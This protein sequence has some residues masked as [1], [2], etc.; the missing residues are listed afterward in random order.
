VGIFN[1]EDSRPE[2]EPASVNVERRFSPLVQLNLT[3]DNGLRTQVGYET[4]RITSLSLSNTRVIERTSKGLRLSMAYTL[5]NFRI[6]FVRRTA[7][8]VDLT[9]NGSFV[10]DSEIRFL[11]DADLDRV[12]Q[13][14]SSV[15][16][17]DP[18]LYSFTPAPPTGQSRI[19]GSA[20][21]GY[22]FSNMVQ[23]NFE[24]IFSQILPKS[25]RTFKRT[26]HDI[27]FSIRINIRST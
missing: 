18:D 4:S 11:L 8:N 23:A 26:T 9:L 22:R 21:I 19:N 1:V 17:R 10:E 14:N 27:R 5:R 12:L 20:V 6:P 25:S 24:Y 13:E 3:W 2:F 7:S 16:E 15:I